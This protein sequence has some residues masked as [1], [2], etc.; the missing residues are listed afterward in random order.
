MHPPHLP[1]RNADAG[2]GLMSTFPPTRCGL[3][4]FTDSLA[5]ALAQLRGSSSS[6]VRVMD[7]LAVSGSAVSTSASS[8]S[9]ELRAADPVSI[10]AA[11]E[12]LNRRDVAIIQHEYGVYGGRDGE[13]VLAVMAL[14]RVPMIT[15]LHTVL[16]APTPH[17]KLVLERVAAAS[18][19]VVVMTDAAAGLL[20]R[21]YAMHGVRITVIP[22][23]VP[24]WAP[25]QAPPESDIPLV[26]TWG[27]IGP[28]KGIEWGIRAIG[29]LRDRGERVRYAVHGQTHPKV[30]ARSG[31][32]YREGLQRLIAESDLADLVVLDGRYL[33]TAEL[34]ATVAGANAV[35]LPYD[36]RNQVTSGVLVEALAAG[37]SVVATRFPHAIELLTA[38]RGVL[39]LQ[40]DPAS[41]AEGLHAVLQRERVAVATPGA[42]PVTGWA[43]V[44]EQYLLLAEQ[45]WI[46]QAA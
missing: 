8:V 35:L 29:M 34:G 22:H 15:V 25:A 30:V 26:V 41:M 46:E 1:A 45:L 39:A 20:R 33:G 21:G 13:D 24:L 17:Q 10:R 37:K 18:N 4:T 16:D 6:V 40:E 2:I 5:T 11:A 44:A 9:A 28:G 7:D 42:A 31:E 3:A 14:V 19:A 12:D 27:L 43:D 38:D 32:E 23:G 36:S